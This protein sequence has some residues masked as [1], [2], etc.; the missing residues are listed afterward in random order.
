MA[1]GKMQSEIRQKQ[2]EK[3]KPLE[4]SEHITGWDRNMAQAIDRLQK[5]LYALQVVLLGNKVSIQ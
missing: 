1:I 4:G 5:N 2:T 3:P